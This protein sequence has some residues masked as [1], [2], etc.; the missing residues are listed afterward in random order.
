MQLQP[1]ISAAG[2]LPLTATFTPAAVGPVVFVVT[3]TAWLSAA[4]GSI[5]FQVY[6]NGDLIGT[7][8]MFANEGSDHMTLPSL[9][10]NASITSQQQQ[11][12]AVVAVGATL[13]DFNDNFSVQMLL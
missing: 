10:L 4:P 1:I 2:P 3:G 6:L 8:S 13:T 5:G 12:I 9:F 11:K 7:A